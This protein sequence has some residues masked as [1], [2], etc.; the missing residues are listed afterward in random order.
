MAAGIPSPPN[1]TTP[2]ATRR[3]EE[4]GQKLITVYRAL[5]KPFE[6]EYVSPAAEWL[7][8]NFTSRR[9]TARDSP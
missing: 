3:L 4:N 8:D 9:T 5:P 1:Q 7:V 6:R 2:V